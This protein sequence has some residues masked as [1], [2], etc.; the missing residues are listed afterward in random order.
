MTAEE[1]KAH[2][3]VH[4]TRTALG[5]LVCHF[6][7]LEWIVETVSH[8]IADA[9]GQK[10][11]PAHAGIGRKL[12]CI[13][14]YVKQIVADPTL[15]KEVQEKIAEIQQFSNRRNEAMHSRYGYDEA[16]RRMMSARISGF[17][18]DPNFYT[19]VRADEI[20]RLANEVLEFA[21]GGSIAPVFKKV[22]A[23]ADAGKP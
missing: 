19:K 22:V 8:Q 16:T 9:A 7:V 21:L 2:S 3:H 5:T 20:N 14:K 23:V 15:H 17:E 10:P 1:R 11:L 6:S 4:E 18:M 13:R 12:E